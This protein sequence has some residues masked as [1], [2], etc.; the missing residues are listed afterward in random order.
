ML[1]SYCTNCGNGNEYVSS[2]PKFCGSC[3]KPI[4]V[5]SA[6]FKPSNKIKQDN[7][8]EDD[9]EYSHINPNDDLK[10]EFEINKG[11][12]N[13]SITL[14]QA[15]KMQKTGFVRSSNEIP[16]IDPNNFKEQFKKIADST[17]VVIEDINE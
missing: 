12:E 4:S 9:T 14:G 17:T 1:K 5:T 15:G 16:G 6:T 7:R 3:G 11:N 2:R 8:R 13:N 10:F